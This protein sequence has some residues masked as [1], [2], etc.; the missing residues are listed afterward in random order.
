MGTT[1][2]CYK[3]SLTIPGSKTLQNNSGM[4]TY[5][6]SKKPS[7]SDKQNIRETVEK[8]EFSSVEPYT[9]TC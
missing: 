2:E 9:W 8:Q 3:L 7:K 6:L 4:A 5:I 1:Q